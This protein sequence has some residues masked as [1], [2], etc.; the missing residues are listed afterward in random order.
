MRLIFVLSKDGPRAA[1]ARFDSNNRQECLE[2]T[3]KDILE[4]V[5]LWINIQGRE[6]SF[7]ISMVSDGDGQQPQ[8]QNPRR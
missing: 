2:G 1:S 6:S 4:E 5:D 7:F 3:R 8:L